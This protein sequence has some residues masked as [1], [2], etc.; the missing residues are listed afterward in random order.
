RRLALRFVQSSF[1][2]SGEIKTSVASERWDPPGSST[3]SLH[4]VLDD[5]ELKTTSLLRAERGWRVTRLLLKDGSE[6]PRE[7][8]HAQPYYIRPRKQA[9]EVYYLTNEPLHRTK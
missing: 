3:I 5:L 2:D 1:I 4:D 8:A 6:V 7:L 9:L